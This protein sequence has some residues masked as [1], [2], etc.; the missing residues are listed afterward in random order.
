MRSITSSMHTNIH[1]VRMHNTY[2]CT[3]LCTVHAVIVC[4][5]LLILF[6]YR[7]TSGVLLLTRYP[8]V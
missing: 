6:V 7:V 2:V 3:E 4:Y 5:F 1:A 8:G